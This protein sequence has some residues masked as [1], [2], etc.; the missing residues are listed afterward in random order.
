MIENLSY[1]DELVVLNFSTTDAAATLLRDL[2][3]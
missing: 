2:S 3:K 1:A